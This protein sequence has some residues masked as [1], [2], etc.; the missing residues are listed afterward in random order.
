MMYQR[1]LQP[2]WPAFRDAGWMMHPACRYSVSC[3]CWVAWF[4]R[5]G[6]C[7]PHASLVWDN[8][9]Q[10]GALEAS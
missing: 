9:E 8:D 4:E 5:A 6:A 1:V 10:L 2:D 3:G 7:R